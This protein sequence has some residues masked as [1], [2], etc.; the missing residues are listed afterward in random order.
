MIGKLRGMLDSTGEDW[1]LVDVAG[2]GYHVHCS[3]RTLGALPGIGEP[4]T[5]A[6]ETYVREDQIRLFGF[7]DPAERDW[8]RLLL[9]VQGVGPRVAIAVLG[10]LSAAE[11]QS[12]IAHK[13]KAM[14]AR[15]PGIGPKVAERI[16]AELKDK[17][18]AFSFSDPA[19]KAMAGAAND[20]AP[21]AAAD[22]VSALL[23]LGYGQAQANMAIA[24]ALS[25]AGEAAATE[26]LIT[27]GLKELAR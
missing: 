4:V 8:F 19:M 15:T 18:P 1:V 24:A 23:N 14:I 5:M 6:V 17:V 3:S 27:L 7:A 11:L 25:S 26:E 12:A 21:R 16:I 10:T 20:A 13:D 2:V 22:A 9:G